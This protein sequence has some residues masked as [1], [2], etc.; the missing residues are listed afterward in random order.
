MKNKIPTVLSIDIG[1]VSLSVVQTGL[2]GTL[3]NYAYEFHKGKVRDILSGLQKDFDL[4]NVVAVVSPSA[5]G[6]LKRHI[7]TYDPQICNIIA[8]RHYYEKPELILLVGAGR[9]Q[10]IIFDKQGNYSHSTTNTSCAAGTGS[11]LDQQ[12][13]RLNFTGI[14]E[15][16]LI[17]DQNRDDLP[18]IASRCAVFAKTDLIHAQQAGYSQ[19][20][21]CDSL[22]KGLAKNIVDT[23]FAE[24]K[25]AKPVLFVGGVSKN[26]AVKRHI[27]NMLD[28][29]LEVHEHSHLFGAIGACLYF[30]D[31]NPKVGKRIEN[32]ELSDIL[33]DT[34]DKR[35]YFH[36]P[37]TLRL[38]SYPE[39]KSEDTYQYTPSVVTQTGDIQVDVYNTLSAESARN[40]Y[41]GFD[42]GSTSTKA[43][44]TDT[45]NQPLAGFYTYTNGRPLDATRAILESI[46]NLEKKSDIQFSVRASGTTGSGRKFIGKIIG[47]DLIIDEITTHAR[48]AYE[49]NS[50]TDTIIEIGGQD[51]KFTVMRNGLVTFSQ[52]NTVCAAGTGSFIEEQADKLGV[53]LTAYSDK[54]EGSP[55]PLSSDRCTVFMERDINQYLN[56]GYAVRE[57]L[58]SVLHSVREN[59]LKKV[60]VESA[61]GNK[62]CFQGATAKNKALVAAFEEKLGKEIFVS[63][64]CHLTG[65]LGTALILRDENISS[66]KFK[67]YSLFKQEIPLSME[68]CTYCNNRCRITIAEVKGKKVAYGFLC[69]R[70]YNTKKF[71]NK[72]RS[73]FDLI[74]E[75]EKLFSV[76]ELTYSEEK[77]TVGLPANLHLYDELPFWKKF[78]RNLG[79]Q[80]LSSEKLTNPVSEG[81]RLAGAEFCAPM[82][83]MYG[84]VSWLADK[85]DHIFLP[86]HIEVREKRDEREANYCYYTQYSPTVV[87]LINDEIKE[88][89]W[90]P[91]LN[92][93]RGE[94]HV[95]RELYKELKL[96]FPGKISLQR[97]RKSYNEAKQFKEEKK[98]S[99]NDLYLSELG[100]ATDISVVFI[101]RPY[102]VLSPSLNKGIPGIFSGMGIKTFYQDMV[103]YDEKDLLDIDYLLRAFPWYF[104]SKALEVSRIIAKTENVYPVFLTAFKC[105]PDSLVLDFFKKML[106]GHNKPY[107]ILQ[108]DEHD[109]NVGYETRIEAGIRAF[110]NHAK[111]SGKSD[112]EVGPV[113]IPPFRKL[114]KDKTV[115]FPNWDDVTGH[116]LVANLRRVGFDVRL[117][118]HDDL[119]M[120]KSMVHNT[121]QCLPMNIM[122]QEYIEYIIKY[123]LDPAK[124]ILWM[125]ETYLT[126]NVRMYPY[127]IKNIFD[128]YGQGMEKASVYSGQLAHN[129]I[130]VNTTY[131]AYFAYMIAG[132]LK[133]LGC[134]IRPRE[135]NQGET[136]YA[137]DKSTGIIE[138]AFLGYGTIEG[139]LEKI[140]PLFSDIEMR[141]EERPQVAI[142]GDFFVRDNDVMNQNLVRTIERSGGEALITPYNDYTKLTFENIVRRR[143]A[144]GKNLEVLGLRALLSGLK[145][146]EKRYYKFFEPWLGK[147]VEID[148]KKIERNLEKFN[149]KPYHSGESYDNILKIF[150]ILEKYPDVSLFVQT[151]PAFCCPSLITEAMKK[152]IHK[153]TKVPIITITYD[154]TIESKND[155]VIPYIKSIR[156]KKTMTNQ[157]II[158]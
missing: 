43:V 123:N 107:L 121:G 5:N 101:G 124:S 97:I 23:L 144:M 19:Y 81:K 37:L 79:F 53:P 126:C 139:A 36:S 147:P 99:L 8:A 62:I 149:I 1:S 41:L 10:L 131:Y 142:F 109:S 42:I 75:R 11:F 72:N 78:F 66:S 4:S 106:D 32:F 115:L 18:E 55:A 98:K 38:S 152:E 112:F 68:N 92:Y 129:E 29:G 114:P 76:K 60:A 156:T 64:Y 118:E 111:T 33:N 120:R 125:T 153:F 151:N 158:N 26:P 103:P 96:K 150:Y 49:L 63:R 145:F 39:F 54:A 146:F 141:N 82:H 87:S 133:K 84:H 21:I 61:I 73:G 119:T 34:G 74:K 140:I 27:E 89:C 7:T 77:P 148:A 25:P 110:R 88:K 105:A 20:A 128:N 51:A 31:E 69:G 15:L 46:Q 102:L 91:F 70:D 155:I 65:A 2:D 47:A 143:A 137:I 135:V 138:K 40:V 35:E 83:A 113:L 56:R 136:D 80:T 93:S 14:E 45:N 134:R 71:V 127:F 132:L 90:I 57:I 3:L 28:I 86:V 17:A 95:I 85:T 58:A 122:A 94:D 116:F 52:M 104:A 154:G 16:C 6:W 24:E 22:C 67:G 59:Y 50:E 117:L 157:N 13:A 44:I 130:S 48:A 100:K 30:L 9:F 108:I 12:A